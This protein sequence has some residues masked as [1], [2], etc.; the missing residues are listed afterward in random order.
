MATTQ[1]TIRSSSKQAL[2]TS[3]KQLQE[4]LQGLDPDLGIGRSVRRTLRRVERELDRRDLESDRK[5]LY[6]RPA[7]LPFA[8]SQIYAMM[9]GS[10]TGVTQKLTEGEKIAL[11]VMAARS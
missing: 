6:A 9:R 11:Q 1:S 3:R 8:R 7:A 4:R 10:G 5:R 2:F